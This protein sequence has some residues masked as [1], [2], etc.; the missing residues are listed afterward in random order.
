MKYRFQYFQIHSVA[1][2]RRQ[3]DK[4]PASDF[5]IRKMLAR[6]ASS[7]KLGTTGFIITAA[8]LLFAFVS[9]RASAEQLLSNSDFELIIRDDFEDPILDS[10]GNE[11]AAAWFRDPNV[12]DG[13]PHT[14]LISPNNMN[15]AAQDDAGDD[16]DGSGTNSMA[17]NSVVFEVIPGVT[18]GVPTDIR[19]EGV[20]TTEGE[21]VIFS[22]DF[23]FEGVAD[24]D[25]TGTNDEG[26][27]AQIRSFA[28]IDADRNTSG[29]FM[30]EISPL[31]LAKDYANDQWHSISFQR[32]IP[33]GGNGTDVRMSANIFGDE[34]LSSGRVLL[35]KV[36]IHRL[37]ADFNADFFVDGDDLSIWEENFGAA[38]GADQSLGDTD[39]DAD[40]DGADYLQ[41]QQEFGLGVGAIA[42]SIVATRAL[43][44]VPEPTAVL[45]LVTAT[46]FL[47]GRKRWF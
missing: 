29:V 4:P 25:P 7:A 40:V 35:D 37:L 16:S 46:P 14:E 24:Q 18:V 26:F 21:N 10:V 2:Q 1:P 12:D 9:A 23:K 41:W 22:F 43:A 20:A 6:S 44:A 47:V 30:G 15:N 11:Q 28:G 38:S 19:S 27:L 32:T 34:Q 45:L 31:I 33:A 39:G 36:A 42:E 3:A 8:M 13:V 5:A 17:L